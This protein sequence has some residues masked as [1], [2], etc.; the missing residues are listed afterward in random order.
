MPGA[1][2]SMPGE[3]RSMP[4]EGRSVPAEGRAEAEVQSAKAALRTSMAAGRAALRDERAGRA[5]AG[6]LL[7]EAVLS[8]PET[9]M[10]GTVAAYLL[11]RYRARHPPPRIRALEAR[12]IHAASAAAPGQRPGLGVVRGPGLVAAGP[13][14]LLEPAEPPRGTAA[15]ASADLVIIPALAVDRRGHRLGRGGGSTIAPWPELA[16]RCRRSRCS[17]MT[18]C[19]MRSRQAGTTSR[20]GLSRS[21]RRNHPAVVAVANI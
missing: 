11:D 21:P 15:I 9:Q 12:R 4:A 17:T 2:Q 18:S 5:A 7:R 1:G 3:G 14:G 10:A 19:S 16:A 6:R 8:L 20:F 13:H